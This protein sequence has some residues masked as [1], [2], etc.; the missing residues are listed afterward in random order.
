MLFGIYLVINVVAMGVESIESV[1][2]IIGAICSPSVS[3]LMPCFFYFKLIQMRKQ[4]KIVKNYISIAS[5]C[6]MTPYSIFSM[7]ALDVDF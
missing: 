5:V 4:P 1:F 2:K 6:I 3:I 7:V